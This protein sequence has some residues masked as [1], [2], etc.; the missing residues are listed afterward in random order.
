MKEENK[1]AMRLRTQQDFSYEA[2]KETEKLFNCFRKERG[3][4]KSPKRF[5]KGFK[6]FLLQIDSHHTN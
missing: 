1:I 6:T 2:R 5:V 3:E 4:R